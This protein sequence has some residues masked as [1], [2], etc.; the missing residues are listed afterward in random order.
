MGVGRRGREVR[1]KGGGEEE[2]EER[3]GEMAV[4]RM[5]K[6]LGLRG[7]AQQGH[8]HGNQHNP[9]PSLLGGMEQRHTSTPSLLGGLKQRHTSTLSLLGGMEQR[10]PLS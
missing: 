2:E 7:R 6:L 8:I 4:R 10:C 9:R 5:P 1:V 3:E